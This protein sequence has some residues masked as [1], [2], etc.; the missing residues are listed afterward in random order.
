MAHHPSH[1]YGARKSKTNIFCFHVTGY[2]KP[3]PKTPKSK[4]KSRYISNCVYKQKRW[5]PSNYQAVREPSLI[6]VGFRLSKY[7]QSY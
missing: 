4:D 3:D 2:M 6:L 5:L 7:V 1:G